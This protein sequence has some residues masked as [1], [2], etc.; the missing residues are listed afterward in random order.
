[1]LRQIN[2]R[3]IL[4]YT[5]A[6]ISKVTTDSMIIVAVSE[7]PHDDV[8][9]E[10]CTRSGIKCLR[11][12]SDDELI[13]GLKIHN[14]DFI[15][16]LDGSDLLIDVEKLK[17]MMTVAETNCFDFI[18][19]EPNA[20][21]KQDEGIQI[22]RTDF[23]HSIKNNI[24]HPRRFDQIFLWLNKNKEIGRRYL[25]KNI[26]KEVSFQ[27]NLNLETQAHIDKIS[28]IFADSYK[29]STDITLQNIYDGIQSEFK[30]SPWHGSAG[31]LMIA[32]I[33]GNHEGDFEVAKNMTELAIASGADCIKFQL[34]HG[35]ALV[36]SKE[37]PE[38]VDHFKKFELS[39]EEHIF[40]AK[41]CLDA[42]IK[43]LASVWDLKMLDWIDP[44]LEY[45][46]IGSGDMTAWPILEEFAK[47]GKPI[48]I[49]TGLSSMEEVLQTIKFL[50]RTNQEY[51]DPNMLCI[52]Q[53]T[54]MYPIPD[55]D[56]NLKVMDLFRRETGLSV[57]Y[58]DHT[59]GTDALLVAA[60]MGADALEFH[61]TDTRDGKSFRDHEVSLD[62]KE[63]VSLKEKIKNLKIFQGSGIKLP[64][65]SEIN[66]GHEI[67]FRRGVYLCNK[68]KKGE[69]IQDKDLIF[70]RPAHGIDARDYKS[71]VGAEALRDIEPLSAL[72]PGIDY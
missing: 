10:Y 35:D 56:A 49:S 54:S 69:I 52:L 55:Q 13:Y 43:Y 23:Y 68:V 1:M 20:S 51:T 60:I 33:G 21:L 24:K 8:I 40:L 29:P 14:W 16:R 42:N 37:S 41:M 59:T 67:S 71:L 61:F 38:R 39:K 57:G 17:S 12:N 48:L 36:S 64:Q 11:T 2:G 72:K 65:P 22:I 66:S 15:V 9:A 70:L 62:K 30:A 32:E 46:K 25:Y 26:H 7:N 50:Q 53:C 5:L 18:K 3:P 19:C 27:L 34:Y 4:S 44:Y 6:K 58:S 47:R 45:Y 28:Q 31:P 63:V